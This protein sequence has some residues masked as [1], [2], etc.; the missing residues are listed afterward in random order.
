MF[1]RVREYLAYRRNTKTAKREFMRMAAAVLPAARRFAENGTA[2]T[3]F[4]QKLALSAKDM[5]GEQL[6]QM[7]L[8]ETADLLCTTQPRLI[9]MA[10][11]MAQLTSQDM[12]KILVHAAVET[13]D[14]KRT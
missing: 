1:Q 4:I 11:S 8:H 12:E 6:I 9:G 5:D 2:V 10:R 3:E 7:A 14:A 13:M